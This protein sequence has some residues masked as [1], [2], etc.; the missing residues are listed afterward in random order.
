MTNITTHLARA[1]K[2][3]A[4]AARRAGRE[5]ESVRLVAVSKTHPAEAVE[6]AAA[7][8]QRIFGENRV[9]EA[10]EKIPACPPGLEWHLL[11]HLQKNKVRQALSLFSFF[12]Q[13]IGV[14]LFRFSP[15]SIRW[16]F[17]LCVECFFN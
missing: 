12:P 15:A 16:K 1:R 9:Q 13:S 2:E 4:T 14:Y 7:T 10:R 3:I 5:P 17:C 11:G 8:G 6:T